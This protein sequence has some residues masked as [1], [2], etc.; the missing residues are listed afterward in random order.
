MKKYRKS[1]FSNDEIYNINSLNVSHTKKWICG[2]CAICTESISIFTVHLREPNN[3]VWKEKKYVKLRSQLLAFYDTKLVSCRFSNSK[4]KKCRLGNKT[5]VTTSPF[6]PTKYFEHHL[7]TTKTVSPKS[8]NICDRS[9][10]GCLRHERSVC[11]LRKAEN[12]RPVLIGAVPF[13]TCRTITSG[14][15][16]SYSNVFFLTKQFIVYFL[17]SW[18]SRRRLRYSTMSRTFRYEN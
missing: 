2:G 4:I 16:F 14:G 1:G 18:W 9:P 5:H 8:G 13:I 17:W 6:V 7:G 10:S 15:E 3:I 11:A 12:G